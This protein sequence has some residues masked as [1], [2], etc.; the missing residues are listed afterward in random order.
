MG[1]LPCLLLPFALAIQE[2]NPIPALVLDLRSDL[3][4][5]P[6]SR[7]QLAPAG[8]WNG[9]VLAAAARPMPPDR[10]RAAGTT[11]EVWDFFPSPSPRQEAFGLYLDTLRE[12]LSRAWLSPPPVHGAI[13]LSEIMFSDPASPQ[14]LDLTKVKSLQE[15]YNRMPPNGSPV[16]PQ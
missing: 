4:A 1:L 10:K 8:C 7:I 3:G 2:P 15:R 11:V 9:L 5:D 6:M 16:K 14:K 12:R 13:E